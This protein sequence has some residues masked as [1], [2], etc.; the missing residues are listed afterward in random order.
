MVEQGSVTNIR[1]RKFM[2]FTIAHIIM[3]EPSLHS[4]VKPVISISFIKRIRL[5]HGVNKA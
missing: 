3:K 2:I 5:I 1:I 4:L